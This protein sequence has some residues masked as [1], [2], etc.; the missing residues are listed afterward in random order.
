MSTEPEASAA[1][2]AST[3]PQTP[4]KP[5]PSPDAGMPKWLLYGFIGKLILVVVI[6]LAVLWYAEIL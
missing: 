2:P 3:A 5:K 6:T 4:A 1:Q